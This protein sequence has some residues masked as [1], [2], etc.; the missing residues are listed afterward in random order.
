MTDTATLK[1]RVFGTSTNIGKPVYDNDGNVIGRTGEDPKPEQVN[2]E[3]ILRA[4]FIAEA[5]KSKAQVVAL[6]DKCGQAAWEAR[7]KVRP[8]S[9]Y[10]NFSTRQKANEKLRDLR[11]QVDGYKREIGAVMVKLAEVPEHAHFRADVG[12]ALIEIEAVFAGRM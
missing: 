5:E 8:S 3:D 4:A 12:E 11:S 7:N 1:E 2:P 9:N 10:L 6:L